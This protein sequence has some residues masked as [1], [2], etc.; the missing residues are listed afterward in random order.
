MKAILEHDFHPCAYCN[1]SEFN[2]LGF[3]I[4]G[5][6]AVHEMNFFVALVAE[7]FVKTTVQV[8]YE[9]SSHV[10]SETDVVCKLCVV[11]MH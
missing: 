4:I 6:I 2:K 1:K 11:L 3:Y 10:T 5:Q 9:F 8:S 7:K